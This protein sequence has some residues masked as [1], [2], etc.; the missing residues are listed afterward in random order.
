[1]NN[2]DQL[3]KVIQKANPEIMEL[4]FGC[5]VIHGMAKWK[6]VATIPGKTSVLITNGDEQ[7]WF[8]QDTEK[9]YILGRPIRLTDVLLA[10]D[11]RKLWNETM[12]KELNYLEFDI[13]VE[14]F[15]IGHKI[16]HKSCLWNLKDDNLDHQS[17]ETKQ[18]LVGLLTT[19]E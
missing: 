2:Y 14:K 8:Q 15:W 9:R 4:K 18:F 7:D 13:E 5:E 6:V 17:E 3:K 12:K 19:H 16:T 1:M 10:I 11:R